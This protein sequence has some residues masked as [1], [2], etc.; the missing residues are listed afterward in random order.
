MLRN[1]K[2]QFSRN[3]VGYLV[4]IL[5][6]FIASIIQFWIYN[7]EMKAK[8]INGFESLLSEIESNIETLS[9]N[10]IEIGKAE[11]RVAWVLDDIHQF[12]NVA[13]EDVVLMI[14]PRGFNVATEYD[15]ALISHRRQEEVNQAI[16]HRMTFAVAIGTQG[17]NRANITAADK[18][19]QK[20]FKLLKPQLLEL[21]RI[22]ENRISNL[23]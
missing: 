20:Q 10:T 12:S 8:R 6:V 21:K 4:A 22:S 15:A 17:L 18:N 9:Y 1:I 19:L 7:T 3:W 16:S 14:G 11:M 13:L 5:A 2:E 23:R